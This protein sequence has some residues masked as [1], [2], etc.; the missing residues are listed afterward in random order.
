[1]KKLRSVYLSGPVSAVGAA[2]ALA[3]IGLAFFSLAN[4]QAATPEGCILPGDCDG[5]GYLDQE[6]CAPCDPWNLCVGCFDGEVEVP[7]DSD[8]DGV[9]DNQDRCPCQPGPPENGGCPVIS[10]GCPNAS[11]AADAIFW[12]QPLARNGASEDTDPSAGG[13]LKYRFKL[14][15]TIPIQIH[16]QGCSGDVTSNANVTG[17]VVVFGDTDCDGAIDAGELPISYNGVGETGGVMDKIGGHLKYNLDTK[18]LPQTV[19]C[20]ILQ[21]TVTDS[22]TGE[23]SVETV[24]L[25]AK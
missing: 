11:F 6:D 8:G 10:G 5:D 24:P 25:Q 17:R 22:S 20:Y 7:C 3:A 15:S 12:H 1:M 9:P 14:G 2:I 19:K 16:A 13:T 21:V 23:S 4:S 18:K